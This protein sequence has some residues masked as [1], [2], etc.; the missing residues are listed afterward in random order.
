ML[1][2][3][4][5]NRFGTTSA[6]YFVVPATA[7]SNRVSLNIKE[8]FYRDYVYLTITAPSAF[9]QKPRVTTRSE[10][11]AISVMAKDP[12][13]YVA[14]IPLHVV[15]NNVLRIDIEGETVGGVAEER[16]EIPM[17]PITP[18]RGGTISVNDELTV[19]FP[20]DAVYQP[21]FIRVAQ[22]E[23]GYTL[24]PSD[25][26]LNKG[27]KVEYRLPDA[28]RERLGLFISEG[29]GW[30]LVA[31]DPAGISRTLTGRFTRQLG[32]VALFHDYSVPSISRFTSSYRR[33]RLSFSFRLSDKGS[34][35]DYDRTR[36]TLDGE[37]LLAEYDPYRH[38]VKFNERRDL[39]AGSHRLVIEAY[40][41]MGN[42]SISKH[43]VSV[44]SR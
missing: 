44:P 23:N 38:R 12:R 7:R 21:V 37:L 43:V 27:A 32:S 9:L 13:T 29:S 17:Y 4:A 2:I 41:R 10:P 16:I 35:I 19:H 34:G 24:L 15:N 36:I 1:R 31:H 28:S 40:D 25:I 26:V 22:T 20:P 30:R 33:G 5:E 42:R 8:E 39:P 6:P 3:E 11:Q 14:A 18:E